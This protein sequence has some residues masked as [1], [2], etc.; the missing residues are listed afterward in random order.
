[1][2][3]VGRKGADATPLFPWAPLSGFNGAIVDIAD[4]QLDAA[5]RNEHEVLNDCRRVVDRWVERRHRTVEALAT[6]SR[7]SMRASGPETI[8]QAWVQWS[9]GSLQRLG[10]DVRDQMD[11]TTMLARCFGREAE[12]IAG[13]AAR[14]TDAAGD[15]GEGQREKADAA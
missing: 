11:L 4:R 6:F 2:T 10:E 13:T 14:T 9:H 12:A 8:V 3:D 7:A 1:M 5:T 15:G